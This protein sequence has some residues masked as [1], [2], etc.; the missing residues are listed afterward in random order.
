[1][2]TK[3]IEK[4][5]LVA[6]T[7]VLL[8]AVLIRTA[9]L[10]DDAYITFRT[11]D[12]F[13]NGYG[14]TWNV[15]E[16]VQTY[17]HPLW[18]FLLSGF[19][20]LTK[21]IY[22]TSIVVSIA[23]TICAVL[24][25]TTKISKNLKLS[26]ALLLILVSSKSFIDYS[27]SGLENPLTYLL[28]AGFFA[29]FFNAK[30]VKYRFFW[31]SLLFGFLALNR[32]DTLL[33]VLPAMV[34]AWLKS[35]DKFGV[36]ARQFLAGILP[37]ILW[38]MFSLVYYGFLFPNT[39]YAK[40]GHGISQLAITGQALK[41]FLSSIALDPI[42]LIVITMAIF[43]AFYSKKPKLYLV[44]IGIMLYLAYILKMGGDQMS[45]RFLSPLIFSAVVILG[46]SEEFNYL[47]ERWA[48]Y[49]FVIVLG[50]GFLS[51][52]PN[53]ISSAGYTQYT[54]ANNL[55]INDERGVFYTNSG[56]LAL[57]RDS[58]IHHNW[59]R[60]GRQLAQSTDVK[61]WPIGNVGYMGYYAGPRIYLL[62]EL[63]L[64]DP[65]L[66]R[67]P[68]DYEKE[69]YISHF[70]RTIPC[71]YIRT[72]EDDTHQNT[73]CDPSLAIYY[74]KL[75]TITRDK[76]FSVKRFKTIAAMNLGHYNH[77]VDEYVDANIGLYRPKND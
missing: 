46:N 20:F 38:E 58:P 30:I 36:R 35:S 57:H 43:F 50:L 53:L 44:A 64:G 65:L 62:D 17:T 63:A 10:S 32:I 26:L 39:A 22:F 13:V 14:L 1:M 66:A 11:I 6:G 69:W 70:R 71:G 61:V 29:V 45:G 7:V 15:A 73:I 76:I 21:E 3:D 54:D 8:L 40:L 34:F 27:T 47:V 25:V 24:V 33:I 42:T 18:M 19:Y 41:Y 49:V 48:V 74:D 68:A 52:R 60:G 4:I 67:L 12:N 23:T 16:R 2:S 59:E 55:W 9:W 56:L 72:L 77:L 75:S 5:S 28:L 31:L 51:P 37:L